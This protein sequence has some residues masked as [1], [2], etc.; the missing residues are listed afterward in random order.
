M[1]PIR[2][3]TGGSSSGSSGGSS[4][5]S[6]SGTT[7]NV[8]RKNATS[9]VLPSHVVTGKWISERRGK[10]VIYGSE[11]DLYVNEWAAVHNPYADTSERAER[12]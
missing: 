4:T 1:Q 9:S 7:V 3:S 2:S 5:R 10:M 12:I 8:E 6:S 11:T